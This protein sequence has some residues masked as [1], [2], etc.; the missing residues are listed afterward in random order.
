ML[1]VTDLPKFDSVAVNKFAT[2]TLTPGRAYHAIHIEASDAAGDQ[3]EDIIDTVEVLVNG[4]PQRT[5][6]ADELNKINSSRGAD[7]AKITNGTPGVDLVTR[8]PIWFA[9]VDRTTPGAIAQ[10]VWHNNGLDSLQIRVKVKAGAATPVL[11]IYG[12][13]APSD[14]PLGAVAKWYQSNPPLSSNLLELVNLHLNSNGDFFQ[15]IHFFPTTDGKYVA[16]L[17]VK[18]NGE[19]VRDTLTAFRNQCVLLGRGM[20]PDTTNVPRYDWVI[21]YDDPIV[22]WLMTSGLKSFDVRATLN[23]ASTGSISIITVR[24]GLPD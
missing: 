14:K 16:T 23:A 12:E 19:E 4:K 11:N 18:I 13:W 17:K 6:T 10:G 20:Q 3:V 9:E 7:L 2:S 5:S 8:L 24:V 1:R 15:A 21:D 22:Q